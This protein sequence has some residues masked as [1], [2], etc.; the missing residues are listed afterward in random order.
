[1]GIKCPGRRSLAS[2]C[3]WAGFGASAGKV[4]IRRKCGGAV[5]TSRRGYVLHQARQPG[6]RYVNRRAGPLRLLPVA[7]RL[8][9][10][11]RILVAVLSI[12]AV[13]VH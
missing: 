11:V 2:G 10:P 4:D 13:A 7:K 6:T 5:E 12:F 3:N 1:M 9:I 8:R